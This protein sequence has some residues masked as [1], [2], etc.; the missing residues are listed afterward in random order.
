MSRR[1]SITGK[2][3]MRGNNVS[4][5]NNKT[6]RSFLPNLH[7]LSFKSEILG[8]DVSL[9]VSSHGL[10]TIEHNG[11][12]DAFLLSTGTSKLT[13]EMAQLKKKVQKKVAA[14]S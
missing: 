6:R 8:A 2:T 4:H 13:T 3:G 11:G 12:L 14:A 9:K 1:C 10:R 7:Q 5:A